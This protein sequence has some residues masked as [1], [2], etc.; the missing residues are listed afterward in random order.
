MN[1]REEIMTI[2]AKLFAQRGYENT[3]LSAIC[4]EAGV[5]KG[6]IF[7]HFKSKELLLREIYQDSTTRIERINARKAEGLPAKVQIKD[8]LDAFFEQIVLNKLGF[9]FDINVMMQPKTRVIL[10]DLIEVRTALIFNRIHKIFNQLDAPNSHTLSY[11]FI[12][13]LD[14]ISLRYFT[15]GEN[16]PLLDVKKYLMQKYVGESD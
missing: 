15:S 11:I 4:K 16:Y 1:K 14:G 10:H 5:S 9:Q 3:P 2:A 12:S 13:E 6:L 8:L 7:H